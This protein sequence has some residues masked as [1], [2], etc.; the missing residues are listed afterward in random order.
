MGD[1]GGGARLAPCTATTTRAW[2]S[3]AAHE[4]AEATAPH[5]TTAS[6]AHARSLAWRAGPLAVPSVPFS[7][8][9]SVSSPC[10]CSA[11]TR[12]NAPLGLWCSPAL[13]AAR[14]W[15]CPECPVPAVASTVEACW[16]K[17]LRTLTEWIRRVSNVR[18]GERFGGS[19]WRSGQGKVSTNFCYDFEHDSCAVYRFVILHARPIGHIRLCNS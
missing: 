15:G 5:R 8:S 1:G 10:S 2:R 7:R 9:P 3:A 14:A 19:V 12:R 11:Y 4:E 18:Q 16:T 6:A 13:V 17:Y